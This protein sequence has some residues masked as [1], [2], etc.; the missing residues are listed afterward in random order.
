MARRASWSPLLEGERREA[1]LTAAREVADRVTDRERVAAA[2]V[3]AREQTRFPDSVHW[4][5]S[6]IA[7]GDAGIALL[8]AQLDRCAPDAG[9]DETGHELLASAAGHAEHNVLGPSLFDGTT[10]LAFAAAQLGR[11]GERYQRMS[12][13]LD[14]TVSAQAIALAR[15]L[16]AARDGVAVHQFDAI[17]GLAGM[18]AYLLARRGRPHVDAA[19]ESLLHAHVNLCRTPSSGPPRWVTPAGLASD[20]RTARLY[21]R[22]HLNCGLAHGIPGPLAVMALAAA[23]GLAVDGLH[24]AMASIAA[25]LCDNRC[26]D[27]WGINWPT[28]VS[29]PGP[30]AL[31]AQPARAAWCYGSPGVAR[32]LWLT[33]VALEDDGL[34]A[35]AGEAMEAVY[36]RPVRVRQIDSPTFCHGVAGLLQITLRFAHD[37]G[38]E[39]FRA[40]ANDLTDQLL[41]AYDPSRLLGFSCIEPDGNEVD[42]PGLLDGAC[43]VALVLLA[44]ATSVEPSWDRLFLL[45]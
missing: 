22:G 43:G 8:C 36:R 14:A 44:A 33:S 26:D 10:G 32:A 28:I 39:V 3:A 2:I 6:G 25:W 9:W 13:S 24:D 17:S 29:L 37:T 45:A 4:N 31:P 38:L 41:E 20:E 11:E 18:G 42:Q 19:L 1:A 35:L 7:Q 21:P 23:H 27:T 15:A 16:D 30:E 5:A 40:A 12:A 34:G